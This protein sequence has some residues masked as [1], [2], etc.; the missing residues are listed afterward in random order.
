MFFY[1]L[2]LFILNKTERLLNK[3]IIDRL[4]TY[5][6]QLLN[7]FTKTV[8]SLNNPSQSLFFLRTGYS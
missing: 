2:L 7:S 4:S 8:V 6:L 3:P 5:L 1:K